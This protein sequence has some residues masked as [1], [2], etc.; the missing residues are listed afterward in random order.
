MEGGKISKQAIGR[1]GIGNYAIMWGWT[2]V[3]PSGVLLGRMTNRL[4]TKG[5]FPRILR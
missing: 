4:G 3:D 2:A 5:R 1:A